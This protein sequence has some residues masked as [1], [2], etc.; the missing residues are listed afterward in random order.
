VALE[1]A[2]GEVSDVLLN[3]EHAL[4]RARRAKG[5]VSDVLL[6][7][8][9]ALDRARRARKVVMNDDVHRDADLAIDGLEKLGLGRSRLRPMGSSTD[10]AVSSIPAGLGFVLDTEVLTRDGNAIDVA[11]IPGRRPPSADRTLTPSRAG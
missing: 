9:H 8:E 5:E 6:N 7:V 2:K 4:D 10:A 11:D 1:S 3:V